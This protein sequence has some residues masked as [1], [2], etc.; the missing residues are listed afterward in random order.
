MHQ[1][2]VIVIWKLLG[3]YDKYAIE[4]KGLNGA[5]ACKY[6]CPER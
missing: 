6:F 3:H 5:R 1:S 4:R 2:L